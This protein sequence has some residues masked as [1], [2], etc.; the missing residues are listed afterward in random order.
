M[1]INTYY[2]AS[3]I[4]PTA[5]NRAE[6]EMN[7]RTLALITEDLVQT[8]L[9]YFFIEKFAG[10]AGSISSG[11]MI[12]NAVYMLTRSINHIWHIGIM[13]NTYTC[14]NHDS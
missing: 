13:I 8:L 14:S 1:I 12:F 3:G 2:E 9:Q 6:M 5:K 4:R 7:K 11:F 10:Q